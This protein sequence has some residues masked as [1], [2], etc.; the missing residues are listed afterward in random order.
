M[1]PRA[2]QDAVGAGGG[3]ELDSSVAHFVLT[4]LP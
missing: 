3:I 1:G 2:G 4:E